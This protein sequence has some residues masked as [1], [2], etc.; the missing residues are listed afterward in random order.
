[1]ISPLKLKIIS[2]YTC[3]VALILISV[4]ALLYALLW[5]QMNKELEHTTIERIKLVEQQL[6]NSREHHAS[7]HKRG[8]V[9][10]AKSNVFNR[11]IRDFTDGFDDRCLVAIYRENQLQYLTK[12]Y[13]YLESEMHHFAI[14]PNIV[15]NLSIGSTTFKMTS[16]TWYGQTFFLGYALTDAKNVLSHIVQ[17]F[18]INLT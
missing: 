7:R 14:P 2:W 8:P 12:R 3:L 6:V 9:D 11:N 18:I 4:F 13:K 5:Y 15:T 17:L 1:M 16:L 10:I